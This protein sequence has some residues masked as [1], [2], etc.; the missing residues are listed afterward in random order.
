[1]SSFWKEFPKWDLWVINPEQGFKTNITRAGKVFGI[2]LWQKEKGGSDI[3]IKK[4]HEKIL[5]TC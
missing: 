1:M 3:K 5:S 4:K 2:E